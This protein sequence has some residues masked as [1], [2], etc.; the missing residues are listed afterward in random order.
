MSAVSDDLS[1]KAKGLRLAIALWTGDLG[2]AEAFNAMLA[3]EWRKWGIEAS[4]VF[5]TDGMPLAERLERDGVPHVSVGLSRGR[6]ALV[7]PRRLA[8]AVSAAG[9]D[10][11]LLVDDSYLAAA[12]RVGGYKGRIVGVEHGKLLA[13]RYL[14]PAR[15]LRDRLE[16]SSGA[17]FRAVDVG[18]SD[19]MV[20]EIRRH[21]HARQVC[22]IYNG[23]D[24]GV[25]NPD[26]KDVRD[27]SDLLRIGAAARLVAGK[28][29]DHLLLAVALLRD[30]KLHVEIAGDGPER[31]ALVGLAEHLGV[32]ETVS[33]RGSIQAMPDF[34]RACDLAVVPSSEFVE[35]FSM[36]TLEAMACGVPVVAT[37]NG[38]IPEVLT[39][40]EAGT[41]VSP[42]DPAALAGA[43]RAYATD[44]DLRRR[45]ATAA[46]ERSRRCFGIEGSAARYLSLFAGEPPW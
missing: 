46:G 7:H 45:H 40:G 16:R 18:V 25:F 1:A 37:R 29:I 41:I 3:H 21:P 11:A 36:T 17:P 9:P 35:S 33:F 44:P 19:F 38:G 34:W 39:D 13:A 20:D 42:G 22:R 12:L 5:V 32:G 31:H 8:R 24:N 10:G 15:R 23:I 4:V 30:L 27:R 28:G 2:G 6:G 26:G 14:S 43:I